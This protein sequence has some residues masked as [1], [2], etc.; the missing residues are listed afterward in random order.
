[1]YFFLKGE[2]II[3]ALALILVRKSPASACDGNQSK[4]KMLPTECFLAGK[5]V[6]ILKKFNN[7][8]I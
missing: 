8:I 3:L 5:N 4:C 6:A 1:M 2:M 7:I